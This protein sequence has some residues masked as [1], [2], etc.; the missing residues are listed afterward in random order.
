[1]NQATHSKLLKWID[2]RNPIGMVFLIGLLCW[3][4][5]CATR[6][7]LTS[8]LNE[9]IQFAKHTSEYRANEIEVPRSEKAIAITRAYKKWVEHA[10]V[11]GLAERTTDE[12]LLLYDAN[13]WLISYNP[14]PMHVRDQHQVFDELTRRGVAKTMH[15]TGLYD[16]M[17]RARLFD[18][19]RALHLVYPH[20]SKELLPQTRVAADAEDGKPSAWT[21]LADDRAIIR[22]PAA[23]AKGWQ[24]V[25][26]S[27]PFC[28]PSRRAAADIF[29]DSVLADRLKGHMLWLAPQD[30]N[31]SY[32]GFAKWNQMYPN[33]QHAIVHRAAEWPLPNFSQTPIFYFLRDGVIQ[34][35]LI[36]WGREGDDK[37]KLI[38]ALDRLTGSPAQQLVTV[39]NLVFILF[40]K[41]QISIIGKW[42][43]RQVSGSSAS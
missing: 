19:A 25:I 17:V 29:A 30:S 34:E 27:H 6:P 12:L 15:A 39:A 3:L 10:A 4:V 5:G 41:M 20:V 31:L 2:V 40:C 18:D 11:G 43:Q 14:A 9:F 8:K 32:D 35:Q 24:M 23:F 42:P 1:M 21:L 16:D 26:V 13:S 33:A 22:R 36:G 7:A 37:T 28:N 38:M